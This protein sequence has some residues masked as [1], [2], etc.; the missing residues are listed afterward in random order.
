MKKGFFKKLN[1]N[2]ESISKLLKHT[3]SPVFLVLLLSSFVLWYT[4]KLGKDYDIEM[5]LNV[6]IDGQ[7][8]R[9]TAQVQG[10]GST[11]MAQRL[12][13]KSK[14]SIKL[15]DLKV[16]KSA[17][18]PNALIITPSSLVKAIGSKTND[19]KVVQIIEMP[20]FQPKQPKEPKKSKESKKKKEKDKKKENDTD[21]NKKK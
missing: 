19:L 13:L 10:K 8:Y 15:T 2:R 16:R 6:R 12:S 14:I 7:R 21:S 18:N 5:P 4:T 20:D 9:V 11:I 3:V 17:E 1:I